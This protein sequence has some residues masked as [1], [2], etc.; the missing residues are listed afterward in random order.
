MSFEIQNAKLKAALACTIFAA[1]LA[2]GAPAHAGTCKTVEFFPG[3]VQ[4]YGTAKDTTGA[5][6]SALCS[7]VNACP[8]G[9]RKIEAFGG[10]VSNAAGATVAVSNFGTLADGDAIIT[11]CDKT[12]D[13]N[14]QQIGTG[15]CQ[16]ES[17]ANEF[18][19]DVAQQECTL[20]TTVGPN[21]AVIANATCFCGE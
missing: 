17:S 10:A 6:D 14:G 15:I 18:Q 2:L 1:S 9:A 19:A 12:I 13:A 11:G 5:G 4:L 21:G 20:Y 8:A 7:A 16:S 3:V